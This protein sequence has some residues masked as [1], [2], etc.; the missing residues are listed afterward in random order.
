MFSSARSFNLSDGDIFF[1]LEN[2]GGIVHSREDGFFGE[3]G[4]VVPD[5]IIS[6]YS[7]A[8]Q[9]EDL[10]NHYSGAFEGEHSMTDVGVR[11]N[12]FVNFSSHNADNDNSLFKS[13]D[14]KLGQWIE[15]RYLK[16]GDYIAVP[17]IESHL[18]NGEIQNLE[19]CKGRV[20]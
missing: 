7:G 2:L 17:I 20:A 12:E 16:V 4:E 18:N 9:G 3:L 6:S 11:N 19:E 1:L 8:E 10:P 13:Y 15:V 5:D 14:N